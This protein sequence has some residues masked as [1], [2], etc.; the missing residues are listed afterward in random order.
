MPKVH[1]LLKAADEQRL[2]NKLSIWFDDD[3]D[4]DEEDFCFKF[5]FHGNENLR[6]ISSSEV[7]RAALSSG[8]S[9]LR[10]VHPEKN[11]YN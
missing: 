1:F 9:G 4:D 3:D 8:R 7:Y 2:E 6:G 10:S 11:K 5:S